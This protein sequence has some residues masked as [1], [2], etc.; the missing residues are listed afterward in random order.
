MTDFLKALNLMIPGEL[1]PNFMSSWPA[2]AHV[3]HIESHWSQEQILLPVNLIW[4]HNENK[5]KSCIYHI[6]ILQRK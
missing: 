6:F 4:S 1:T 2:I 5:G 3:L